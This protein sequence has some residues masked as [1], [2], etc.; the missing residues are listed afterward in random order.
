MPNS[1]NPMDCSP[2]VSSVHG[3]LQARILEWVAISFSRGSLGDLLQCRQL[4]HCRQVLYSWAMR[5]PPP[6][7][8]T[9]H[10]PTTIYTNIIMQASALALLILPCCPPW[11]P[12]LPSIWLSLWKFWQYNSFRNLVGILPILSL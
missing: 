1:C 9:N 4:L 10:P 8:P 12:H 7:H 11:T 2:P 6:N 5:A 3:I